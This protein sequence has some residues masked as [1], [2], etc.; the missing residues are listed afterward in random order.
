MM[1]E[2]IL[3]LLGV[4][5]A[6]IWGLRLRETIRF[7]HGSHI[8]TEFSREAITF[9]ASK[10]SVIIPARNEEANIG[11]CLESLSAQDYPNFEIIVVD[12]RSQD[13][14]AQIVRELARQDFRIRLVQVERLPDGWTG[15]NHALHTGV[16]SATGDW[17]LFTDADTVHRPR[18]ISTALGHALRR[19]ADMLSLMPHLENITFWEKVVQ[20]VAGAAL[21]LRFP[22]QKVNDPASPTAFGNGQ[23]ILI[24]KEMYEKVG[25]H[26]AVK[27]LMLEDIA[28]SKRVKEAGLRL[29]LAYGADLFKTRMYASF[30]SI[31]QGWTRIFYSAFAKNGL[32]IMGMM[33]LVLLVSL[34]PYALMLYGTW[35]LLTQPLEFFTLALLGVVL[36][37]FFLIFPTLV[38]TYRISRSETSTI[39]YHPLSCLILLGILGNT[40]RKILFDEGVHWRGHHYV[41]RAR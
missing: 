39:F 22:V 12:D 27:D 38:N 25:G 41:E 24:K 5:V 30:R 8:I 16:Q 18:S 7:Y 2:G 1:T 40:L 9:P 19:N 26:S 13:R 3:L 10:V 33:A 20:P 32:I 4:V 23:Y 28:I 17:Y 34:F 29:H 6:G 15:K 36:L 21:M 35:L 11:R 37:Q 14:T 31:W